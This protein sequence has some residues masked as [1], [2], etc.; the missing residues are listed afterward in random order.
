[1]ISTIYFSYLIQTFEKKKLMFKSKFYQ[2]FKK[3]VIAAKTIFF[4]FPGHAITGLVLYLN[5]VA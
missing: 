2:V 3:K 4:S 5:N 1:M